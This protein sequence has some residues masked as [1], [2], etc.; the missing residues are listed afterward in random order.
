MRASMRCST[1][2]LNAAAAAATSQMPTVAA[3]TTSRQSGQPRR[4]QQHAD[5]GAEDDQLHHARLGQRVVL[6][7]RDGSETRRRRGRPGRGCRRQRTQD[8]WS[9]HGS[10]R[11][12]SGGRNR[13]GFILRSQRSR[14]ARPGDRARR[15]RRARARRISS[16]STTTSAA[17]PAGVRRPPRPAASRAARCRARWR[18]CHSGDAGERRAPSGRA[19]APA[20]GEQAPG[21]QQQRRQQ[22]QRRRGD[23]PCGSRSARRTAGSRRRR[24]RRVRAAQLEGLAEVHR[25]PPAALAGRELA[26]GEHRVVGADPAAERDL[27]D[28]QTA[29]TAQRPR[30][31]ARRQREACAARASAWIASSASRPRPPSR[32]SVTIAG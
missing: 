20:G 8:A 30:R 12:A 24:R 25:R 3:G 22:D 10:A 6:A 15:A 9:G 17:A 19:S 31:T 7:H 21:E 27:H 32:C 29:A 11:H 4:R 2:Q 16:V 26:A 13:Q 18:V 5:H 23:A 1:R 14:A 28:R